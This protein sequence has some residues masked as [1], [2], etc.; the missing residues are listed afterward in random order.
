[1]LYIINTDRIELCR[2]SSLPT[3]LI[4]NETDSFK[5]VV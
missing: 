2:T 3:N 5:T 4:L 1:M